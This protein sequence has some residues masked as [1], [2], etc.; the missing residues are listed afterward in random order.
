MRRG[1]SI[2][3]AAAVAVAVLALAGAACSDDGE[4]AAAEVRPL[5]DVLRLND[6]QVLGS[7]NSYHQEAAPEVMALLRAFDPTLA[8]SLEYSHPPLAEQFEEQGIRQIELDV[9]AD[10]GLVNDRF[11]DTG[12]DAIPDGQERD[13]QGRVVRKDGTVVLK[14]GT[15]T[16]VADIVKR[17][18]AAIPQPVADT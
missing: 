6:L 9:F 15:V 17:H 14:N 2:R 18:R 4:D 5:D 13:S 8:D 1:R 3:G 12:I 7:H 16:T 10:T 11:V